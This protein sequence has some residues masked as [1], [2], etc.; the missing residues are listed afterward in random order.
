LHKTKAAPNRI[1]KPKNQIEKNKQQLL[2]KINKIQINSINTKDAI[3][4]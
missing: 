4:Q 3:L 1:K 2:N